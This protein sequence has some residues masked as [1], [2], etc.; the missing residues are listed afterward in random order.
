MNKYIVRLDTASGKTFY[1]R[2]YANGIYC[3]ASDPRQADIFTNKRTAAHYGKY[4]TWYE[5]SEKSTF[6]VIKIN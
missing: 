1:I 5:M 2:H 4:F 6:T 3:I